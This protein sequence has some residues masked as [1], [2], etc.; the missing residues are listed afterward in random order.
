M[1]LREAFHEYLARKNEFK[2]I[3]YL[4]GKTENQITGIDLDACIDPETGE[5]SSFAI[6][7]LNRIKPFY[8][9]TSPS[10]VGLRAFCLG[11]LPGDLN[12]IAGAGSQDLTE[13]TKERI[14]AV[15]PSL[16]EKKGPKFNCI[17]LYQA[18]RHLS[19]TGE[20]LCG[21]E[22]VDRTGELAEAIKSIGRPLPTSEKEA[23]EMHFTKV[24]DLSGDSCLGYIPATEAYPETW[25]K[26]STYGHGFFIEEVGG[27]KKK[28]A[29]SCSQASK[30]RGYP[31][32]DILQV[33]KSE[34]FIITDASGDNVLGYFHK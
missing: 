4:N 20:Y 14:L 28:D 19:L 26:I 17:E 5:I 32:I 2:G 1:T 15:K 23:Y 29:P 9:E 30:R 34:G 24:E 11:K 7:F 22:A 18:H 27:P 3:G 6:D 10:G 21:F 25:C 33:A 31:E 16:R 8:I 13:L 12:M